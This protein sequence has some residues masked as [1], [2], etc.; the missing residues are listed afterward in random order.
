MMMYA[1]HLRLV[2]DHQNQRPQLQPCEWFPLLPLATG[3]GW[4]VQTKWR[5]PTGGTQLMGV[6]AVAM[7]AV[8]VTA[9]LIWHLPAPVGSLDGPERA[10]LHLF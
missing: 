9:R 4:L 1:R 2:P 6:T 10:N 3:N 8:I 5:W 7:V